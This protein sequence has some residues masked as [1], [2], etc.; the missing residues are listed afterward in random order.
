VVEDWAVAAD[1]A[2]VD[3]LLS[4]RTT[5]VNAINAPL[6]GLSASGDTFRKVS[7]NPAE[8]AGILTLGGFLGSTAHAAQTSPVL[9]GKL[10]MQKLL[11]TEPAPPPPDVPPLPASSRDDPT[12]TRARFEA[13]LANP[14]CKGCHAE[15]EPMGD[16][17]EMYDAL[18]SYRTEENG[19]P[20]DSSGALVDREGNYQPVADAVELAELVARDP[21]VLACSSRQV[22]R[23]VLGR[24]ETDYDR[25]TLERATQAADEHETDLREVILALVGS[26][27]FVVRSVAQ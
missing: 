5:F 22:L 27:S 17:F 9:R 25:C 15:F 16:A 7:L 26:D 3:V 1:G 19:F 6:Y 13:H 23:F 11:C 20:I 4:G 18:G 24:L 14:A 21:R 12:T 10:I 2:R 8:R